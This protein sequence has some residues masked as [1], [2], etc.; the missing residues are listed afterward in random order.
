MKNTL[1]LFA[2]IVGLSS[3][4]KE[5]Y[6]YNHS[7]KCTKN[8]QGWSSGAFIVDHVLSDVEEEE[9]RKTMD[10]R[11]IEQGATSLGTIDTSYV[12]FV[13]EAKNFK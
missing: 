6:I 5:G 10:K 9:W 7:Y 13:S 11:V 1:I 12:Y 4:Q 2:L 8:Q 3:C